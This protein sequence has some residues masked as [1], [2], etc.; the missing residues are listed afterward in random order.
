MKE[1]SIRV[2]FAPSP[3]GIMHLGNIRTALMNY[4]FA[5]QKKGTFIIRIEDTDP[6][7]NVDPGAKKILED[8]AWLG[9]YYDEGPNKDGPHAPYFQSLRSSL[10]QDE[11][12]T[13]RKKNAIYRCFC[14][15][16]LLEKKRKRQMTL[17]QPPRYDRTCLALSEQEINKQLDNN[18]PFIWRFK[19]NPEQTLTINDLAH[20][21]VKFE[22][23]HF[24]D[25]PLTRQDGSFTFMFTNF[26]DDVAMDISHVLRGEDHLTN[27]AGQ[28]ALYQAF[29]KKLPIFWHLPIMCNTEG[30]KLS[31][32]DFG[33]SLHDL[34]SAGFLPEALC[35]Y[36]AIIGGKSFEQ[37]IMS[38]EELTQILDFEDIHSTGH[39]RYD[40]EKLK[41]INH[42]WIVQYNPGELTEQCLPFLIA[43]Y[44]QVSSIE[45]KTVT[46][47]IQTIKT[48]IITLHDSVKALKFYFEPPT[49]T[50]KDITT[51]IPVEH[52]E[53]IAQIIS[54]H[55]EQLS[56]P[57]H[58]VNAIKQA[59]KDQAIPIAKTLSFIRLGLMGQTRGPAIHELLE[60]LGAQEAEKR[61]KKLL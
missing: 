23:K 26:V 38:L 1:R 9:L 52:L 16:E 49:L 3:T 27:T 47:L 21:T 51:L 41:W 31:K 53:K 17:K 13:L 59:S 19:L 20:G 44:P 28:A 33:F 2:R 12:S 24:S 35:N 4:L 40:V 15:S 22:F 18:A 37:E 36:L 7:R 61:I 34:K 14:P 48:D 54:A 10:Y 45:K 25:F 29:D 46:H 6:Q 42:K 57:H 5:R 32:R 39:I 11:L 50:K 55:L 58:F 8:L 60:M 56:Q 43:E 30:K